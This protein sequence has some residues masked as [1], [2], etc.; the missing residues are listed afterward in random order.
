M[1]SEGLGREFLVCVPCV[2]LRAVAE[3]LGDHPGLWPSLTAVKIA[4]SA[5]KIWKILTNIRHKAY[6][7]QSRAIGPS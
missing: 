3:G 4:Y 1:A 7:A 6:W 5:H 2:T